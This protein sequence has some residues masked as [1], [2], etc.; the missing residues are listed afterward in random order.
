MLLKKMFSSLCHFQS[1]RSFLSIP[2]LQEISVF[3]NFSYIQMFKHILNVLS[4]TQ[5]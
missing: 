1:F 5:T 3:Q 4:F 2:P